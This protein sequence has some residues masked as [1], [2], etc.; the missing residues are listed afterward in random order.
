VAG[1]T[2]GT[3][4][5]A[6]IFF[7][8]IDPLRDGIGSNRPLRLQSTFLVLQAAYAP[9]DI[10]IPAMPCLC[11]IIDKSDISRRQQKVQM[12]GPLNGHW[13]LDRLD[14]RCRVGDLIMGLI[15]MYVMLNA[16]GVVIM[17]L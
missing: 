1:T 8:Q 2:I 13:M 16:E 14:A 3:E 17:L 10:L 15:L 5:K 12:T 6:C 11:A 9:K 7:L 4:E